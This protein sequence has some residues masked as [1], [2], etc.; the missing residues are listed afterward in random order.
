MVPNSI[1]NCPT[2]EEIKP[3]DKVISSQ[4]RGQFL[5]IFRGSCPFMTILY[6]QKRFTAT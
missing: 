4:A 2:P 5:L 6:P 3:R 1:E